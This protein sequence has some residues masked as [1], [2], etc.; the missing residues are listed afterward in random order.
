MYKKTT[1]AVLIALLTGATTVHAQTDIS[2]IESRLAALEQRL[3][4]AESRAQAAEARAKTAELQVQK[5]AETQ[6]QNQLTTQEVAQ[7]TVQLEQKSAENSGFEFHGYARSGLLM[8]DAASSSKSG[9]YLTPAGETGGAVGRLGNEADTYVELNVEHKQTLDNGATTRFK[10]MLADGQR[11]Y[12]DW[13]GGSSN[14]NIRQAFAEL[15]ALP[16]FT[17]AFKDSTVWAGKRFDCDNFDIHWLD[18]DVVFLAGTG[19]GIYD[20]KWNDTFRS[21]FSLYGRNFGDLDDI[22]NNVQNYILTMNHYA[23]PFQ[24]MVSGLRAKDNDDRKDANGDLIQTDAANTGVHALVGLHNDTFY[25]LREGTAKTAL[26]YGHGLGAEV[27]GI[28]SDGALLSE[29]NTWRFASYGTT[30]LGSG[31]YVAPAIL[32]QSSK[33]RYVKGDSYEWV[34]FNT[35]LIKEVTQNFA[36]AFEGSYQYMDLKPKGYQNHNAV[37]G[38]FYKLTF[39]PTLKANDINNF[40]SRPELRLFATWMDWS[41][42]LDD[43]ASNDAFGSSGFNTGGE[44]NFGVQMETWF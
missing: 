28:G 8:N 1:L 27:K 36:L 11:D 15:G 13:T 39:A 34:T 12:N 10:A 42:K 2:S 17:G 5:L 24:L 20:V 37:N 26:L 29:A 38:S 4:N 3:K 44:W 14:L 19:G 6:Q 30:P 33:D 35:R 7:R 32:A 22:D 18:S 31:W 9:P 25:G 16:S 43:F 40:F 21:N 41:S 23:G